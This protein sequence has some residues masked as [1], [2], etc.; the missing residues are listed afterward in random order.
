[1]A[2]A[3][4]SEAPMLTSRRLLLALDEAVVKLE[5]VERSKTEPIA[6]VGMSCRF[7]GAGDP[8]SFWLL[9]RDGVDAT[10]EVPAARWEIDNYYD[11]DLDAPGKMYTR[12]GGFLAGIDQFDSQFFGISPREAMSLDPQQRLLLEVTWEALENAGQ[13]R[14]RLYG[15]KTGV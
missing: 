10:T 11:P 7:P 4:G 1:M 2:N 9:L 5:A 15:S 8:D 14:E 13:I 12:Y 6:I 3:L